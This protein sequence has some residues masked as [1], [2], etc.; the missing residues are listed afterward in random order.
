MKNFCVAV[1]KLLIESFLASLFFLRCGHFSQLA[2]LLHFFALWLFFCVVVIKFLL[3]FYVVVIFICII[4]SCFAFFYITVIFCIAI[5]FFCIAL[6]CFTSFLH[7]N[8]F[9][10]HKKKI[11][12]LKWIFLNCISKNLF[13]MILLL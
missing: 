12:L 11:L 2:F 6:F 1:I 8:Y 3:F 9:L 10:L 4:L 5:I 7:C 13:K